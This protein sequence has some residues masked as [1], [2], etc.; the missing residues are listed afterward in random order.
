MIKLFEIN[1]YRYTPQQFE[2]KVIEERVKF[3][4]ATKTS[5]ISKQDIDDMYAREQG[6][7]REFADYSIG[8]IEVLYYQGCISYEAR[9]MLKYKFATRKQIGEMV[10]KLRDKQLYENDLERANIASGSYIIEPRKP[11]LFSGR[12]YYTTRYNIQGVYS[13]I[14]GYDNPQI[15][16]IIKN[17]LIKINK[18]DIFKGLYFDMSAW[19]GLG[20]YI[21][22]VNYI[23]DHKENVTDNCQA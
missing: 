16:S 23:K 9:V 18:T 8:A 20:K 2:K 11:V 19:D 1:I 6:C 17:D 12:K 22:F 14:N 5:I 15:I 21:D 10:S 4:E 3:Y 13:P 7:K